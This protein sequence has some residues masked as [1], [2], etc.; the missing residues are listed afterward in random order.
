[1]AA[2]NSR[3]RPHGPPIEAHARILSGDEAD[4]AEDALAHRYGRRRHIMQRLRP[5]GPGHTYVELR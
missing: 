3:G 1:V 2:C 5:S 4:A